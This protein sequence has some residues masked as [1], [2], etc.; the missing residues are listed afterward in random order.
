MRPIANPVALAR[1]LLGEQAAARD[2]PQV[3]EL[4]REAFKCRTADEVLYGTDRAPSVLDLIAALSASVKRRKPLSHFIATAPGRELAKRMRDP[5][6]LGQLVSLVAPVSDASFASDRD[7]AGPAA[8][9]TRVAHPGLTIGR[10]SNIGPLSIEGVSWRDPEQGCTGDCYL[11]SAMIAVAWARPNDWFRLLNHA[12]RGDP[13]ARELRVAFRPA[14]AEAKRAPFRIPPRVPLDARGNL[15]YAHSAATREMW[16]ALVERAFVMHQCG[17]RDDAE[18][19]AA[20]YAEA[21]GARA[22]YP[23]DAARMLIGGRRRVARHLPDEDPLG[24]A[25]AKRCD[26]ASTRYP[27]MAYTTWKDRWL[28]HPAWWFTG[29]LPEHS[30]AVLGRMARGNR[31]YVVLVDPYGSHP[32]VPGYADGAWEDGAPRNRGE[33]VQL[34]VHG[35]FALPESWFNRMFERVC[36]V[37]VPSD[38]AY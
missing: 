36:W 5:H 16:P 27:T 38:R 13:G 10:Y 1:L 24:T 32:Q 35:V 17:L 31:D 7:G 29:L 25:V 37:E 6:R 26:G 11:I 4:I 19:S 33:P 34:G 28:T 8:L 3:E 14:D 2:W 21:G 23:Q 22:V 30:Y 15:I 20:D 18:P 9:S 12:A